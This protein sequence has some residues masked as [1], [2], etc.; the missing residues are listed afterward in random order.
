MKN[1]NFIV[2]GFVFD[3]LCFY[4]I[5]TESILVNKYIFSINSKDLNPIIFDLNFQEKHFINYKI[6]KVINDKF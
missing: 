4:Y 2:F 6:K 3:L 5:K 1:I